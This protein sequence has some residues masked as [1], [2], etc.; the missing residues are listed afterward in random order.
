MVEDLTLAIVTLRMPRT[1]S[2]RQMELGSAIR[3]MELV[4][5][6]MLA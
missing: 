5:S 6:E 4:E 2:T 1:P 3:D